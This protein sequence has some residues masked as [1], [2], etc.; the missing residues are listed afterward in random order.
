M[1]RTVTILFSFLF[2]ALAFSQTNAVDKILNIT[3]QRVAQLTPTKD[4][5]T[6]LIP[7]SFSE[8]F[9]RTR[10]N[11]PSGTV[12]TVYYLYTSFRQNPSFDQ[13][14]LN[15]ERIERL[16]QLMPE[17][18]ENPYIEWKVI[19]QTGC[20]SAEMGRSYYHGF[21]LEYRTE[22]SSKEREQE[23][24]NLEAFLKNPS[25][26]FAVEND[27]TISELHGDL[28]TGLLRE[29]PS[30]DYT[31]EPE[32]MDRQANFPEGNFA[33]YQY[34]KKNIPGGGEV[35]KNR[36]DVWVPLSFEVDEEGNISDVRFAE[37]KTYMQR[38]IEDVLSS[39][40]KWDPAIKNGEPVASRV[41]IELRMSYS[42]IVRGMYNRDGKKPI[43]TQ[44]EV[45]E[46]AVKSAAPEE[47]TQERIFK[48][49]NSAVYR[50]MDEV[51]TKERIAL[52]M[53]VTT[54][55]TLHLASMNWWV[56]NSADSLNV[57]HYTF[58]N[59]GDNIDDKKKK[60]G[61][62]GGIYHGTELRDLTATLMAAMRNGNGGDIV[63]N[64]FEAVL[65][66]QN[67]QTNAEALLLI[68]DNFSDVRDENLLSEIQMKTHV[69][70]AGDVTTVR[71]CYLN[72]AKATG[73]DVFVNGKRISLK[74]VQKGGRIT[75]AESTYTYNGSTFQLL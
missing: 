60:S 43:F 61:K 44:G 10:P 66:A 5:R 15:R 32:K 72:L 70:L 55:M 12:Q 4:E 46:A 20:T 35:A 14:K 21:V 71:E 26:G 50:S 48:A 75:I 49:E 38:T 7:S 64:D 57:V 67:Q 1:I 51:I 29:I 63:E 23:I 73:G 33:L 65:A 17:V 13:K 53:D 42:P 69:L 47:L 68:V 25:A 8:E 9:L 22:L 6:V 37:A 45:A 58:F 59:D 24:A 74:N 62:T 40:P 31:P 41:N 54:S 52:V 27:P 30:N 39:M 34:F 18:L 36:D 16:V 56:A 3:P 2:S 19:E 28:Q 11:K